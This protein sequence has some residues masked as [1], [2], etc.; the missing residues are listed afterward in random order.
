MD[1]IVQ[2]LCSESF[3]ANFYISFSLFCRKSFQS[4][5]RRFWAKNCRR[6]H[7]WSLWRS[8]ALVTVCRW[9]RIA[10]AK[11][12]W[13]SLTK[14]GITKLVTVRR[15][16]DGPSCRFVVKIREVIPVPRFQELKYFG[17]KTLDGPLCLWWSVLLAVE[18][19]EDSSRR[20][21]TSM[22]RRSPWRSVARSVNPA[23]FWKISSN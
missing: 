11:G 6:D 5:M 15:G 9:Q 22:E 13:G 8:F 7:L 14:C 1:T 20:N 12:R 23:A 17:T 16:S 4:W 10:A 2:R 19:N 21:C 18:G 3:C